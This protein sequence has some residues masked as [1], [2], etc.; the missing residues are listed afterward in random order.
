MTLSENLFTSESNEMAE[1]PEPPQFA[2]AEEI[3]EFIERYGRP[4]DP[5]TDDYDRPPF[6]SDIKEGKNDPIYNAHSYHT[7][8]PPRAIIPYILHYTQPGDI[9][10]DPFCGS[11]MTGVAAMMCAGPAA[12]HLGAVSRP[13][14]PRRPA[15]RDPERSV[16]R[17]LPH[18]LQ[19]LH[20]G[21]RRCAQGAS[22][23]G[24]RPR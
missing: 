11:G 12:G 24:S 10:L 16:S 7:K 13:E 3:R 5:E 19:L 2:T 23:S 1:G 21:R 18:R 8:V 9:V 6:V 20:A 17:R 14:R 22:S 4:Y 15:P